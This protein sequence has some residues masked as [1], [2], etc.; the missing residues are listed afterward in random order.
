MPR[1]IVIPWD[2]AQAIR[3]QEF[4]G[5]DDYQ[6][7]VGGLIEH[8]ELLTPAPAGIFLNEEGRLHQADFN[9]RATLLLMVHNQAFLYGGAKLLGDVVVIGPVDD[10]G[11]TLDVP[12]YYE[13]LLLHTTE[14]KVEV[15]T[16]DNS[17]AWNT[18]QRRFTEM[19]EAYHFGVDLAYRW[20][21]V[22]RVRVSAA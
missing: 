20:T 12:G 18:N 5:L 15:Q 1:G 22:E 2:R 3:L 8:V 11:E 19:E 7:A 4:N 17:E 21:A 16:M 10:E 14:Y 13:E 6:K 9:P